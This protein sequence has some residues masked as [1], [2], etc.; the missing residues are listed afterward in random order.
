[1]SSSSFHGDLSTWSTANVMTMSDMLYGASSFNVDLSTLSTANV[2]G[3]SAMFV[4][5]TSMPQ[6]FKSKGA[7]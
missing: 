4:G 1:M 3:M 2:R 5:A 6:N 7:K